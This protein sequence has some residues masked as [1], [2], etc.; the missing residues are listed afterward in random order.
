MRAV[1][2]RKQWIIVASGL[3]I[4]AAS[5]AYI[6]NENIEGMNN[7]TY[8]FVCKNNKVIM[9][10]FY[11]DDD[12]QA[13]LTLYDESGIRK[14]SLPRAM[15]GSGAR[16]A[17]S[18]E[19]A[20]FW[21]KGETAFLTEKNQVTFE[22]CEIKHD[23]KKAAYSI[24]GKSTV[25]GSSGTAY[26]GN[27]AKADFDGNGAEDTAFLITQSGGGSGTFFYAVVALADQ[28]GGYRGTNTVLLGDRISPQSTDLTEGG[29]VVNYADRALSEPMVTKPHIALSKYFKVSKGELIESK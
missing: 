9:A 29:F 13:D 5:C 21:N 2:T 14:L 20:V 8:S 19:S 18:D 15:S 22:G 16:Y 11:I 27:E 4:L 25:L 6:R 12:K 1:L 23:Y 17:N 3:L 24:D 10:L 26:F 7:Q 28:N